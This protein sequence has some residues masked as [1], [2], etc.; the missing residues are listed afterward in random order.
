MGSAVELRGS[1]ALGSVVVAHGLSCPEGMWKSSP[2]MSPALAV[3]FLITGPSGKSQTWH[4][5]DEA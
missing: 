2:T 3:G 1:R 5:R 4:F